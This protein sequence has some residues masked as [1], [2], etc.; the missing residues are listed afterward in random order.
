MGDL[1]LLTVRRNS[2]HY[3]N[4]LVLGTCGGW[5]PCMCLKSG[6]QVGVGV[7]VGVGVGVGVGVMLELN[8]APQLGF[9]FYCL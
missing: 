9:S 6:S 4:G 5:S 1:L 3:Y 7:E 2:V 8:T